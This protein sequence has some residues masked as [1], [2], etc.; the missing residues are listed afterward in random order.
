MSFDHLTEARMATEY[1]SKEMYN[2]EK[3]SVIGV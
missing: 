3:I 1:T 2:A